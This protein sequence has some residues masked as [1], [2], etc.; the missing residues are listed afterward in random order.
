MTTGRY[1]KEIHVPNLSA[2]RE[3][4]LPPDTPASRRFAYE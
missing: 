2:R 3:A 1:R 4:Y